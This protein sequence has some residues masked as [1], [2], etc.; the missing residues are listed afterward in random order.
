MS[1]FAETREENRIRTI[2]EET[3]RYLN[4]IEL[5][6]ITTATTKPGDVI[7]IAPGVTLY[8]GQAKE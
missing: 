2:K 6:S 7:R 5:K 4:E 3:R 8:M 1:L